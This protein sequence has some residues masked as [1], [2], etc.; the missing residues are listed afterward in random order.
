LLAIA[1]TAV[2]AASAAPPYLGRPLKDVIDELRAAGI[3]IAYSSNLLASSLT[4]SAEPA[5]ADPIEALREMLRPHGLA[6]RQAGGTWLVVR[7]EPPQPPASA[8]G[9][10]AIEVSAAAGGAPLEGSVQAD[11]PT[12]PVAPLVGGRA[13]LAGLMPGRHVL[14]VRASGYLAARVVVEVDAGETAAAQVALETAVPQL[15]E[16]TVT[17]SRYDVGHELRG[18]SSYFSRAEIEGLTELGDDTLRIAHRVPG[19]AASDYSARSHVRGGATDEMPVVLD[20]M[21]LIEPFHLRDYQ[22]VFS[23]IDPHVVAGTEIYSGG[24]PAAYGGGLSGLTVIDAH[25]PTGRE[26]ELGLSLLYT[27]GLAGGVVGDGATDWLISARRGNLDTLLEEDRGSP[28]YRDAYLH[29][30]TPLAPKHTL[31]IN[32]LGFDDDIALR[33]HDAAARREQG[34]TATDTNQLWI[35]VDSSWTDRL[36]SRS[37]LHESRFASDRRGTVDDAAQ[38]TGAVRDARWLDANGIAQDWRWRA[39]GAQLLSFGFEIDRSDAAY[40]YASSAA[41]RGVLGAVPGAPPPQRGLVANLDGRAASAYVADRAALAPRL[42]AE[43]GLRWERETWLPEGDAQWSPRASLLYRV[44]DATDLRMSY[45]RYFQPE[46]LLDLQVEDGNTTFAPV[47]KA[48]HSIVGIEHRFANEVALRAELYRKRID[49]A[50][51]RYENLFDPLVLLPELRPGRVR[52]APDVAEASGL[53]LYVT[54]RHPLD[55]WAGY[56]YAHADDLIAGERIPRAWDQ[57]HAASAGV[58][59]TVGPWSLSGALS[60]HSGWPFTAVELLDSGGGAGPVAVLGPRN[61]ERLPWSRRLDVRASK[62]FPLKLGSLRLFVEIT[63]LTNRSNP[64]CVAYTASTADGGAATLERTLVHGLPLAG[65][66]GVLW[67]F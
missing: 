15:E 13:Q 18:S 62:P 51:P 57:R 43:L 28:S 4:V 1:L 31:T 5:S 48:A 2:F 66:V 37:L 24:F 32:D 33:P 17:A 67:A 56:S 47:Q 27:S 65:N 29:V 16:L 49:G 9:N 59:A 7:G 23:A 14:T 8:P 61:G 38:L 11:A 41:P 3:A 53:E 35:K 21:R 45:G 10:V 44:T 6:L 42:I 58:T 50:Q 64:C 19:I 25:E 22:A 12:G 20:G 60:V 26:R 39:S 63:N 46:G 54:G 30:R 34:S 40:V 55:W 52:I 36:S